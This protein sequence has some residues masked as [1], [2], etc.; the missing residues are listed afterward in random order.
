MFHLLLVVGLGGFF[1]LFLPLWWMILLDLSFITLFGSWSLGFLVG[2]S[3]L[4]MAMMAGAILVRGR[5]TEEWRWVKFP[6][7]AWW[8]LLLVWLCLSYLNAPINQ[9]NRTGSVR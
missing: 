4:M 8:L 3:D 9:P 6:F 2:P 7:M 5:R 1:A